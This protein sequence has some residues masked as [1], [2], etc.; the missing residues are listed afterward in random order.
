M[1][2][3]QLVSQEKPA[4]ADYSFQSNLPGSRK[5]SRPGSRSRALLVRH[6]DVGAFNVEVQI[7]VISPAQFPNSKLPALLVF[8]LGTSALGP[9]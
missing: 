9:P 3:S 6:W 5:C 4:S 1:R 2:M 8:R 7:G